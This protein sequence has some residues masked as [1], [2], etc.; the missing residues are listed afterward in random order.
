MFKS[1]Q[2]I[3]GIVISVV[4]FVWA[5][6]SVDL[7]MVGAALLEADYW[8][9]LPAL[10]LYFVGVWVRAGRWRILLKPIVPRAGLMRTFEIVVIGY[11]ANDIL[12]ARIGELV[13]AYVLSKREGVRKTAT[14]ATIL[15]ERIFDGLTMIGFAAAV[16]VFVLLWD[17]EALSTGSGHTL[18]TLLVT[19]DWPIAI[20]AAILLGLLLGFVAVASSRRRVQK[21]ITF[22]LRFLPGRL[23]ERGERLAAS[24]IDG[25][26]S[27]RSG[28][29]ISAV[30]GLS[31]VAWLFETGM[32][33]VLGT[34][35]FHLLGGDGQPLP[36]YAYMLAT[37]F[38][39]LSTLL[40]Q[41]PGYLG[42]FHF[43][44]LA[45][46]AGAFGV[47][48]DLAASYVLVLHAAL[49]L[50]VTLVGFYYLW[51][52][53][54]SWSELTGLEQKRAE[55]A[56]QAHELEGPL[57]DIELVQEGK[58]TNSEAEEALEQAGE[59]PGVPMRK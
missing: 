1:R 42:V 4:F 9:L 39:N 26:G 51:R 13:R 25:L 40:P 16:I 28:T 30:F 2:F 50:P 27:L 32:Y 7:R 17:P 47:N 31:I 20:V 37:A 3:I 6:S 49:V 8:A 52:E 22:G 35:G 59:R 11:M 10:A 24:F 18:G 58:I 29:S 14:L 33:Y 45:V 55:A 23:H 5:L 57:T 46:L 19:Y 53:S 21:L 56:V 34:W 44:A 15:V 48:K 54:L 38:V 36:F 43:V 12:P 41:A